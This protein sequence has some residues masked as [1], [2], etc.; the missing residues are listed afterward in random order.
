MQQSAFFHFSSIFTPRPMRDRKN[1]AQAWKSMKNFFRQYFFPAEN[2]GKMKKIYFF[3][4][5]NMLLVAFG[6][7]LTEASAHCCSVG[8]VSSGY[9]RRRRCGT[10]QQTFN[11]QSSSITGSQ[12]T[13]VTQ[14]QCN[15]SAKTLGNVTFSNFF[16][17]LYYDPCTRLR[18]SE[19]ARLNYLSLALKLLP[20]KKK[21]ISLR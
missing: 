4:V 20:V 3:D 15:G 19:A 7:A 8:S 5:I 2:T 18:L 9:E 17:S 13:Y 1:C 10:Q 11:S 21:M 6:G 14:W 16:F 12:N